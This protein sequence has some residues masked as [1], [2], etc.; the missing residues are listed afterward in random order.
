[1][2]Q[3]E[4]YYATRRCESVIAHIPGPV[5]GVGMP[6]PTIEALATV[7]VDERLPF[8]DRTVVVAVDEG[9]AVRDGRRPS[10]A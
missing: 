5:E 4:E 7:P 2:G 10:L 8:I 9:V 1:M 6:H 3:S